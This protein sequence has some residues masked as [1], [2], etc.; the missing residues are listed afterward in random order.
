MIPWEWAPAV[1]V[2]GK[3]LPGTGVWCSQLR[4]G[5]CPAC[6]AEAEERGQRERKAAAI[7]MDLIKLLGGPKPYREFTFER[8]EVTPENRLAYERSK[9]FTSTKDNLYLWGACGVG[10]THLTWAAARY[11][12]QETRSVI[13]LPAW[14]LSRRVR[15]KDPEKEQ[16]AIDEFVDADTLLLDD[17]G[18]GPDTAF[19]RQILQEVLDGRDFKERAGLLVTSK[20]SLDDLAAKLG[21]D[22]I[23]SRM[24]GMCQVIKIKGVDR[25][26]L[27]GPTK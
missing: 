7:R 3:P 14:Q 16:A 19:S 9:C 26:L 24:A 20:Y 8:Y 6:A 17:L 2:H 5:L 15:M 13:I 23:P 18:T 10:K 1:L 4:D 11:C 25:R 22:A 21:D 27:R 12:F